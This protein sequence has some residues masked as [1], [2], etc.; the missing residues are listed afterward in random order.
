[1]LAANRAACRA[2]IK[3]SKR[4]FNSSR[5]NFA[6]TELDDD[7]FVP[8][9]IEANSKTILYFT[10]GWCPPC[11]MIKPVYES[12]SDDEDFQLIA[13]AKVD[14]DDCHRASERAGISGIPAFHFMHNGEKVDELVGADQNVL[15]QK[16]ETHSQR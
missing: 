7:D 1:M 15:R 16:I 11:K 5:I 6:V 8:L 13:F 3:I 10:A 4:G 12:L 9:F 14:V 2:T